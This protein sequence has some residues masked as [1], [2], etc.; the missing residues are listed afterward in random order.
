MGKKKRLAR[1]EELAKLKAKLVT[2]IEKVGKGVTSATEAVTEAEKT[3]NTK[4][5]AAARAPALQAH[6]DGV[7]KLVGVAK[8]AITAGRDQV[9]EMNGDSVDPDLKNFLNAELKKLEGTSK[10]LDNRIT[11]VENTLKNLKAV[12]KKK[13]TTE[14]EKLRLDGLTIMR[15]HRA[16]KEL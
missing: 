11:K 8:E 2:D 13:S 15:H 6:A 5:D 10:A 14:L 3:A 4:Q 1:E 16:K 12:A 7:E 9:K